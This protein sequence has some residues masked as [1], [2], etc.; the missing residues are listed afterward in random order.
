LRWVGA[1]FDGC[2]RRRMRLLVR[3]H[4]WSPNTLRIH[5]RRPSIQINLSI[6]SVLF[7]TLIQFIFSLLTEGN[8]IGDA[9]YW[10]SHLSPYINS[11]RRVSPSAQSIFPLFPT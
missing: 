3:I 6:I 1:D 9:G 10:W 5:K 11:A 8:Q 7:Y 4:C 2:D